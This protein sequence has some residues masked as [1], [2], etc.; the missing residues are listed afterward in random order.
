MV[1]YMVD[2]GRLQIRDCILLQIQILNQ[3][4]QMRSDAEFSTTPIS[5]G[6]A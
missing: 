3:N 6:T 5:H 1:V 2:A 4:L